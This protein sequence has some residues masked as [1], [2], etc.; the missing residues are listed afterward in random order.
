MVLSKKYKNNFF[1]RIKTIFLG[2]TKEDIQKS[3]VKRL[4]LFEVQR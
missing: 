1:Q 2:K 3:L 4:E